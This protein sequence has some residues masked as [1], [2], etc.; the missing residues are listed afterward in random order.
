MRRNEKNDRDARNVD[1]RSQQGAASAAD[2]AVDPNLRRAD[3]GEELSAWAPGGWS[4]EHG[5]E[6]HGARAQ[7]T[8]KDDGAPTG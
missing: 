4:R 8:W 6:Q 1:D 5:R 2:G 7:R 3:G